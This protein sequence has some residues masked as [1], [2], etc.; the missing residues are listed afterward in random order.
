MQTLFNP[1]IYDMINDKLWKVTCISLCHLQC[2]G[3]LDLSYHS[4]YRQPLSCEV[5]FHG[6]SQREIGNILENDKICCISICSFLNQW[7]CL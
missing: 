1:H 4:K 2:A 5:V 6:I 3:Y 7:Q